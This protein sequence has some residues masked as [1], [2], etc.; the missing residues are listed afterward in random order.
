MGSVSDYRGRASWPPN[1]DPATIFRGMPIEGFLGWVGGREGGG[2]T[3]SIVQEVK[4]RKGPPPCV[5]F[6]TGCLPRRSQMVSKHPNQQRRK[7]RKRPTERS[8]H[9]APERKDAS[10]CVCAR[11]WMHGTT[12]QR[13]IGGPKPHRSLSAEPCCARAGELCGVCMVGVGGCVCGLGDWDWG[14]RGERASRRAQGC[15][16]PEEGAGPKNSGLLPT[17]HRGTG[18]QGTARR[19]WLCFPCGGV[20][21][22]TVGLCETTTLSF[23]SPCCLR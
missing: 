6:L 23:F 22:S 2:D 20:L 16:G 10:A 14:D 13:S 9:C 3:R 15:P 7:R 4:G 18:P 12:K 21:A 8:M 5:R 17:A 11:A 19:G 1:S